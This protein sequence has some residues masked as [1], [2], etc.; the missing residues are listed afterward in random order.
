MIGF[1]KRSPWGGDATKPAMFERLHQQ[2]DLTLA[3]DDV[4]VS[5]FSQHIT[6]ATLSKCEA[7]ETR[8]VDT[9]TN[10]SIDRRSD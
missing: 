9:S 4:V 6:D 8:S 5:C 3:I 2:T 1:N 10:T 7:C